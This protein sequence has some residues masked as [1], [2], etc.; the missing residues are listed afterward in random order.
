MEKF[1]TQKDHEKART[2]EFYRGVIAGFI[3]TILVCLGLAYFFA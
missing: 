3:S 1:V 2:F